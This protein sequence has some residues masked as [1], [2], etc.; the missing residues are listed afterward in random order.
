MSFKRALNAPFEA[1]NFVLRSAFSR[2]LLARKNAPLPVISV[3]NITMGGTGKTPLVEALAHTLLQLGERPA[4]LTRG[5]RRQGRSPLVLQ[6]DPGSAWAQAGDEPSLLAKKLPDVPVVVD[7]NRVRAAH[8]AFSLGATCALLDDGFQH[9]PLARDVDLVVVNARDPLGSSSWRREGPR[10][11]GFASRLVCV[12]ER[13]DQE[14]ARKLLARYHRL[15]PFPV[16]A[17]PQGFF[18]ENQLHPIRK[19]AGQKLLAFAGIAQ[20]SRF[21][22]ALAKV[23]AE[24]VVTVPFPDHHPYTR[25][26]LQAL[27]VQARRWRALPITTAKDAVRLPQDLVQEVAILELVMVPQEEPF[28][29]LLSQVLRIR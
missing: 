29:N 13:P 19:L 26:Q 12:G 23:G 22:Q 11:L 8:E 20:P 21:F 9:W 27:L 5:Y 3:G 4:I 25:E 2:G 28:T 17:K 10:A 1:F 16:A 7:A 14:N 15:P 6:G 18:W 24:L